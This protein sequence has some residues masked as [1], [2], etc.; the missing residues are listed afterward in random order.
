MFIEKS[1]SKTISKKNLILEKFV[2]A[3]NSAKASDFQTSKGEDLS[4]SFKTLGKTYMSFDPA[5]SKGERSMV[6][7]DETKNEKEVSLIAQNLEKEVEEII[8]LAKK[9]SLDI[10]KFKLMKGAEK[11]DED[12][13]TLTAKEVV[14]QL[15]AMCG[16]SP[17]LHTSR[18]SGDTEISA[19]D[20]ESSKE[21]IDRKQSLDSAQA[22]Y[23]FFY[24]E[25]QFKVNRNWKDYD[26][27]QPQPRTPPENP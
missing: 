12:E 10:K 2:R 7:N 9:L 8:A 25:P 15:I 3:L 17:P 14:S 6:L 27:P 18:Q 16:L 11:L 22:A 4:F 1:D 24:G 20:I 23:N 13:K 26:W 5:Y 21:M 19:S